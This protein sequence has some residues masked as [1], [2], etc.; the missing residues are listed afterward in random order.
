MTI[1][2]SAIKMLIEL[3]IFQREYNLLQQDINELI[4]ENRRLTS[5]DKST[6]EREQSNFLKYKSCTDDVIQ[7]LNDQIA[8]LNEVAQNEN[9]APGSNVDLIRFFFPF[10]I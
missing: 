5:A 7:N 9:F 4:E 3:R 10:T 2:A 6:A 1:S 8:S